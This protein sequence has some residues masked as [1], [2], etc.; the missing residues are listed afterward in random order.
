MMKENTFSIIILAVVA[1]L[2]CVGLWFLTQSQ[3][4]EMDQLLSKIMSESTTEETC[5]QIAALPGS[6]AQVFRD[7]LDET[8]PSHASVVSC[9]Y[10]MIP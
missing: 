4:R 2:G 6:D 1:V 9:L 5:R 10:N 8:R 7:W 3:E